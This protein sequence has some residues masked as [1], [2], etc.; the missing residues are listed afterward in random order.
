MER[1]GMLRA[2]QQIDFGI[3]WRRDAW[4][5]VGRRAGIF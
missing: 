5:G 4:S 3:R 2:E 1:I